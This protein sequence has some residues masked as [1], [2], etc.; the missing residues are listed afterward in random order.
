MIFATGFRYSFPFLPQYCDGAKHVPHAGSATTVSSFLPLDGSHVRDLYLDQFYLRDPTL[1]F[2]GRSWF[3][4][5]CFTFAHS[6]MQ[7]LWPHHRSLLYPTRR[8]RWPKSGQIRQSSQTV[9]RCGRCTRRPWR[10][11]ED[12][13]NTSCSWVQ[14]GIQASRLFL[15]LF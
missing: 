13:A 3:C 1:A 5:L 7:S 8:L 11:A 15:V 10:N 2:L 14:N 4:V 6:K 9:K 12:T